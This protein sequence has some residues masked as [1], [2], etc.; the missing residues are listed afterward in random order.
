MPATSGSP[1]AH[2]PP[3]PRCP[4]RSGNFSVAGHR[5][6]PLF[7]NLQEVRP[8]DQVVVQTQDYWYVYRV[9]ANEVVTPHSIEVV[10]PTPARIWSRAD[11][12]DVDAHHMQPEMERL[13]TH[14]RPRR[15]GDPRR[16]TATARPWHWGADVYRFVWDRMPFGRPGKIAGLAALLVGVVRAAVVRRFPGRRRAA[17]P[18]NNVQVTVPNGSPTDYATVVPTPSQHPTVPAWPVGAGRSPPPSATSLPS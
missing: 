9:T 13:P 4:A 8:G 16:R 7:W 10:A 18:F 1:P 2:Y 15:A 17:N 12:R 3:A 5:V 14:G 6:P 11:R